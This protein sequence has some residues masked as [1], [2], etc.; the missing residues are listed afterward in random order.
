MSC[1]QIQ[2]FSGMYA[3]T[4]ADGGI[5]EIYV[6]N[7]AWEVINESYYKF[8]RETFQIIKEFKESYNDK[9]NFPVKNL[10]IPDT[11]ENEWGLEACWSFANFTE[12]YLRSTIHEWS[13]TIFSMYIDITG[14]P[15]TYKLKK[16]VQNVVI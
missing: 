14:D 3:D 12:V 8:F 11:D 16:E 10:L 9:E 1:Q 15:K 7:I 2:H 13:Q 5:I 6:Y 4:R